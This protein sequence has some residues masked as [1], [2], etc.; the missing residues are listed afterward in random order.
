MPR[1]SRSTGLELKYAV[2]RVVALGAL[3]ALAPLLGVVAALVRWHLGAPIIF[4]QERPGHGGRPFRIYK[5]RTMTDLV[6]A[7]GAPLPDGL[8][9]TP[10]GR[11]LRRSSLDELP[12]LWNVVRGEM[13][14]VGPRPLLPRYMPWFTP[15]E[16]RRF[17]MKPGITGLAQIRG[18]NTARWDD[19][20]AF[21]VWYV[22][23]WSP[24]LDVRI[25]LETVAKI[26]RSDGVV[27]DPTQSM[28]DLDVERQRQAPS[29]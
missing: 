11:F 13:S 27:A 26:V 14:L 17:D 25:L 10:F 18:R 16:R 3:V 12:E 24:R 28:D 8:R 4:A 9:L 6:D 7:S 1:S 29:A 5:F 23:H 15:A 19:R 21:D 20:L 2:D 22:D